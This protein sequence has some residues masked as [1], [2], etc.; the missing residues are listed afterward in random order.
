MEMASL[1]CRCVGACLISLLLLTGCSKGEIKSAEE[2]LVG[3]LDYGPLEEKISQFIKEQ[4]GRI[5]FYFY[6]LHSGESIGVNEREP[7]TAASSIKAPIVLYLLQ[8]VAEGKIT[9]EE[10]MSYRAETDYSDGAGAIQFFTE[11][12][13]SY[14]L[15]VLANLAISVSDNIAWK[16]LL[17]RLGKDK[18]GAYF[19]SLG[20]ETVYPGGANVST[21][22]DLGIYL[23]ALLNFTERHPELGERLLDTMS[24]TIYDNEGIPPGVP[25]GVRVAHKVG[26]VTGIA[27]DIGIV[28]LKDRP[29]ILS[30]LTEGIGQGIDDGFATIGELSRLVYEYQR[31]AGGDG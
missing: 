15:G 18:I 5:G 21:A 26:T 4:G 25:P 7:F 10:R 27:N 2:P 3:N 29:Y 17:R 9:L 24:H 23:Q 1:G 31:E 11:D 13:T 14:S 22:R 19:R 16:M 8:Q 6:D 20:G 12:G 30:V 28:F